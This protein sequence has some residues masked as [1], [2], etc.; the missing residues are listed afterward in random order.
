MPNSLNIT[1]HSG[2]AIIDI[3][4]AE[5]DKKIARCQAIIDDA[6]GVIINQTARRDQAIADKADLEAIKTSLGM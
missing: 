6:N 3:P 1:E 2:K 4:V 5:M